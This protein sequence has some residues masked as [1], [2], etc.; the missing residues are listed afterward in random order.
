MNLR[1]EHPH[2]RGV[3]THYEVMCLLRDWRNA[4]GPVDSEEI[5]DFLATTAPWRDMPSRFII[6]TIAALEVPYRG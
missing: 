5:L 3:L 2:E 6:N 4:G 1:A